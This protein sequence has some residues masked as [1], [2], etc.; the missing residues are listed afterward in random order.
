MG[1]IARASGDFDAARERL[2][3]ALEFDNSH[4]LAKAALSQVLAEQGNLDDALSRIGSLEKMADWRSLSEAG[5]VLMSAGRYR[6]ALKA[7]T[8]A[9]PLAEE[10]TE[11]P[12]KVVAELK[13][14]LEKAQVEVSCEGFYESV[15]RLPPE[16]LQKRVEEKFDEVHGEKVRMQVGMEDGAVA[17]ASLYYACPEKLRWLQPLRGMPLRSVSVVKARSLSDLSPLKGIPLKELNCDGAAVSD[18]SPLRGMPLESLNVSATPVRELT[19]LKG[20][21]LKQLDCY[22]IGVSDLR[23]LKGMALES[24]MLGGTKVKDLSPLQ[25]MPLRTLNVG[26]SGVTDLSPLRGMPL[27]RLTV[28]GS[29]VTD[30]SPLTGMPLESLICSQSSVTDL[31]PL[32]G[33]P[34]RE[35]AC[36]STRVHDLRPLEGMP[37]EKLNVYDARVT[38]LTPLK[39]MRLRSIHFHSRHA[40]GI[41]KGIEVL[42]SMESLGEIGGVPPPQF[43]KAHDA[44]KRP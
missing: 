26:G 23:P 34:L 10:A 1:L 27:R 20:M 9:V 29:G 39:G 37:L 41:V 8:K 13:L 43:W 35:L 33:M 17:V 2:G 22:A 11:V 30:L 21:P 5:G 44:R 28:G 6:Q 42:R 38:D 3:K 19:A 14:A 25:G 12:A 16:E 15:R 32:Q 18:L 40:R 31:S 4:K 36:Q 7:Y 24:L